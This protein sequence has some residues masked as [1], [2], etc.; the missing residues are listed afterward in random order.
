M[1]K[2]VPEANGLVITCVLVLT[3]EESSYVARRNCDIAVSNGIIEGPPRQW[4]P[5]R[6]W[7]GCSA[8]PAE[9]PGAARTSG[10]PAR[11]RRSRSQPAARRRNRRARL[12]AVVERIPGTADNSA[13]VTLARYRSITTGASPP[14]SLACASPTNSSPAVTSRARSM[15]DS[16]LRSKMHSEVQSWGS[17]GRRGL[18]RWTS[19]SLR[20]G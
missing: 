4:S 16:P 7:P 15:I 20:R 17:L 8:Q 18:H 6:R 9:M 13:A 3:L 2:T 19:C 11:Q 5:G 14:T 10:R 12:P 1:T